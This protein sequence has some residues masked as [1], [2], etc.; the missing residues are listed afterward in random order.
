MKLNS[1][2]SQKNIR[3]NGNPLNNSEKISKST[4]NIKNTLPFPSTSLRFD[5]TLNRV[6]TLHPFPKLDPEFYSDPQPNYF[7]NKE[8]E[9]ARTEKKILSRQS[10]EKNVLNFVKVIKVIKISLKCFQSK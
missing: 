1:V 5:N 3:K 4:L 6:N 7:W 9:R 2:K 10:S 8:Q